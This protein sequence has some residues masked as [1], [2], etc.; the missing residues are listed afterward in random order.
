MLVFRGVGQVIPQV[1]QVFK[2]YLFDGLY[3][4]CEICYVRKRIHQ[5][6]Q[7]ELFRVYGDDNHMK[8]H[9]IVWKM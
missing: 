4:F 9:T 7:V 8:Y 3:F 2:G 1:F 6:C 5:G